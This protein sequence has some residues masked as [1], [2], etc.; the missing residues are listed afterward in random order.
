M[1]NN[2][3]FANDTVFQNAVQ[4]N[5]VGNLANV[6][7]YS[8]M[9]L[10]V[11]SAIGFTANV[12]PMAVCNGNFYAV[13]A[14]NAQTLAQV[15]NIA[16]NGIYVVPLGAVDQFAA[17]IANYSAGQITVRGKSIPGPAPLTPLVQTGSINQGAN[18]GVLTSPW[19]VQ[20]TDGTHVMPTGDAAARAI[21][22][23]ISDGTNGPVS[24]KNAAAAALTDK[25]LVVAE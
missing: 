4:A 23:Q 1:S 6:G 2:I 7:G 17:C 16:A 11:T 20:P 15:G 13:P 12:V 9:E 5:A 8:T 24:V 22:H 3:G 14:F 10:E 25:A 21:F 19:P 18:A